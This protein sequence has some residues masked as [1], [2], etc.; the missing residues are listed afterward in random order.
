M[1]IYKNHQKRDSR[2]G[3]AGPVAESVKFWNEV[4]DRSKVSVR[5]QWIGLDSIRSA[6]FPPLSF[7]GSESLFPHKKNGELLPVE[8][9]ACLTCC[10][11]LPWQPCK[12]GQT[13]QAQVCA[14][15]KVH[16]VSRK[17]ISALTLCEEGRSVKL[18]AVKRAHKTKRL[19]VICD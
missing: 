6:W 8:Y 16:V 12:R 14:G 1:Y 4:L 13:K 10:E 18:G 2:P 7:K 11:P 19:F 15:R 5:R 9:L 3:T 17:K